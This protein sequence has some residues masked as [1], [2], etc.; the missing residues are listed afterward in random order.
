MRKEADAERSALE[1][2]LADTRRQATAVTTDLQKRVDAERRRAEQL[3][4]RLQT[5]EQQ[6]RAATTA[7]SA[8]TKPAS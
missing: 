2:R 8:G 1:K 5:V 7:S 6:L 3:Q 4:T